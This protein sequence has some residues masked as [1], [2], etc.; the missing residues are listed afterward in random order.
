MTEKDDKEKTPAELMRGRETHGGT[1]FRLGVFFLAAL[2]FTSLFLVGGSLS[3]ISSSG[4]VSTSGLSLQV[5]EFDVANITAEEDPGSIGVTYSDN[6]YILYAFKITNKNDVDITYDMTFNI[7]VNISFGIGSLGDLS[8]YLIDDMYTDINLDNSSINRIVLATDI[9]TPNIE[10]P[11][12]VL[13]PIEGSTDTNEEWP[14]FYLP[15]GESATV[16]LVVYCADYASNEKINVTIE[17]IDASNP[18]TISI[19]KIS[20]AVGE[21][22]VE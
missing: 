16:M 1:L 8:F 17:N 14:A 20:Q 15:K 10:Q 21:P 7:S 22:T 5:A 18:S 12:N 4:D 2:M 13:V 6:V 11:Q 9:M 3:R 19:T